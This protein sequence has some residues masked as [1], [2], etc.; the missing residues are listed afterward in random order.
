MNSNL[1]SDSKFQSRVVNI[2]NTP[3]GGDY[4]V[5]IQSM[6]TVNTMDTIG[7]VEQSIRLIKAGC[8]YVRITASTNKEA[9]NLALIKEKLKKRGYNVP[10]IADVHFNPKAAEISAAIVEKVRIN[11]GNYVDR[12]TKGKI[13]YTDKEYNQEI[14]KIRENIYPLI[15]IC[16]KNGT[17]MRIGSNHGSLSERIMSRYGD[18]PEGMVEAAMEFV[19]ICRD[20]DY[21]N[22]ILSMKASNT[23]VMVQAN[24]L[25]VNR[26]IKEN[27]N[28]PIHLG[29]TEAG[30]GVPGRI[31]SS[32]G[33][34]ALLIDGIG[35]TIRVSLTEDPVNE[36]PV[37]I[38]LAEEYS[39]RNKNSVEKISKPSYNYQKFK[40]LE[41][42]NIGGKNVPV[43]I[44]DFS[45]I[46]NK[47]LLSDSE[48]ENT[49]FK[50]G[51]TKKEDKWVKNSLCSDYF[52]VADIN[53]NH[54]IPEDLFIIQDV[55]KW[56]KEKQNYFPLFTAKEYLSEREKSN[57]Q[58]FILICH[59]D[60]K[61]N[62][63]KKIKNDKTAILVI[64][65]K[66]NNAITEKKQIL[67]ELEKNNCK[68]PVILKC[69]YENTDYKNLVI[70]SAVD[71][72]ALFI[73]GLGDGI[74]ISTDGKINVKK[75]TEISFEI[76][77][78][79][80]LRFS[81]TEYISC[82]SCGRTQ[83]N[84]KEA[85]EKIRKRTQHL[86]G[87]TIG[88]MGC[89]VN[90]PGEMAGADYGYVGSEKGKITLFKANKIVK[91]NIDEKYAVDELINIIKENGDWQ[92]EE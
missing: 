11:P 18:T 1:I 13:S 72:G 79:C 25:L 21:H 36:V 23:K 85:L 35:D 91:K 52:Y 24:R 56:Q 46:H 50:E 39:C 15:K 62:F 6:T 9:K 51:F 75:R 33:I 7:N 27:L 5:R 49:L 67:S 81:K 47:Y 45:N 76:L 74:W 70:N 83:Y 92:D 48:F 80:R 59:D 57:K 73:D 71:F 37:A 8:H 16:K 34:G 78:A 58:N 54:E 26:M 20:F 69:N 41:I 86:K 10:L 14:E 68:N 89:I 42:N 17:A 4:P 31:K 84:I 2:G 30:A 77:Q 43:V 38:K 44:S 90:G 22:I 29:V 3:L 64:E 66:N 61:A 53:I 87:L 28:Y 60:L 82:P 19:N 65:S 63:I 88:V 32:I 55:E 12:N 40:S